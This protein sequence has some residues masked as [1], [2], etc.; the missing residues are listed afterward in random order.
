MGGDAFGKAFLDFYSGR[1]TELVFERDDGYSDPSDLP[2]YFRE[3]GEFPEYEK[4]VLSYV[5][6]KVLDVG[7][8]TGRHSLWLQERGFD[9]TSFDSSPLV[10]EVCRRRGVRESILGAV[11]NLPFK[12]SV[13]DTIILLGNGFGLA[14]RLEDTCGFLRRLCEVITDD[15]LVLTDSRN[16]LLTREEAHLRYHETN[17]DRGRPTGEVRIRA[18]CGSEISSWFHLLMVT[19]REM[20]NVCEETG[21][22]VEEFFESN[23]PVFGAVLRKATL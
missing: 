13:F 20:E 3:Y 22:C 2:M 19:P 17:R 23:D 21:W 9:V 8:G 6:G 18:K 10:M 1:E 14:G 12:K 15:G 7:C 16:Y 11:Q 4:R 5:K